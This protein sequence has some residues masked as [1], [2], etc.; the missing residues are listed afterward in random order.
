MNH[1]RGGRRYG[2]SAAQG[3]H[4]RERAGDA[5]PPRDFHRALAEGAFPT[6]IA[7]IKRASPSKGPLRPDLDPA[8]LARAYEAGGAAALSILTEEEHFRGSLDDLVAG[9]A[10]C[11]LPV[12]RKDFLL[13]P[14][15]VYEARAHGA[16]AVLLIAAAL[17]IQK[18]GEMQS[19][20]HQLGMAAL[21]EVHDEKELAEVLT[22]E[23]RIVGINNRNLKTFEVDLQT[24]TRLV[25][26]LP[27]GVLSVSES[28]FTA[29]ADLAGF[30]NSV[31]AF[32]IGESLVTSQDSESALRRL[33]NC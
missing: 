28:G 9:R 19:L 8:Q 20:A 31:D 17:E 29:P 30:K 7:E 6:V 4:W 23:P 14:W 5:P 2:D 26:A 24:T 12:L 15:E 21:V 11:S 13:E 22:V 3:R 18:L 27:K 32:L 16:D 10:A 33:K 25:A 1:R